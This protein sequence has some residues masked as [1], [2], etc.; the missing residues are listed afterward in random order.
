MFPVA[1]NRL[2]VGETLRVPPSGHEALSPAWA[3]ADFVMLL[4]NRLRQTAAKTPA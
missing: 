1:G 2:S 4:V 3:S